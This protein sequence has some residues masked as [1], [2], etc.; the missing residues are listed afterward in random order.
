MAQ[1]EVGPKG[2]VVGVDLQPIRSLEGVKTIKGDIAQKETLDALLETLAGRK[3]DTVLSDMSPNISGNYSMD[4][5][6]SVELCQHALNFG[7]Q[8]L[9]PGGNMAMKIFEGDMMKDFLKEVKSQFDFV[10]LHSPAASRSSSSEIY[11]IAKG[12]RG[13]S[14][15]ESDSNR[16]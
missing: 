6:R 5:A 4:H 15:K 9:K 12:F 3:V 7:R 2:M 1:E 14:A 10:K 13:T 16:S 8:V 11:I